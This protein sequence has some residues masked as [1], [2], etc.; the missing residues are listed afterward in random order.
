MNCVNCGHV[1]PNKALICYWCGLDPETGETPYKALRVSAVGKPITVGALEAPIPAAIEVASPMAVPSFDLAEMDIGSFGVAIPELPIIEIPPPPDIVDDS[2]F[3]VVRRRVRHHPI[4]RVDPMRPPET[5]PALPGCRRLLVFVAGLS[6]LLTLG[7]FL[8]VAVAAASFGGVFCLL[9]LLA[10]GA[11]LWVG[12]LT[13]RTGKRIVAATGE[14]Y[15]RIEVM[16]RVLR[17]V[18]PGVVQELPVNLPSRIGV[19]DEPVAYSELRA[20]ASESEETPEELA[21]DLFSGAI[22][23]LVGRDD[24]IFAR[25]TYPVETR[26]NLARSATAEVHQPVL[27]RRRIYTGPGELEE[28]IV[29]VLRTDEP[30]T[31]EELLR[32]LLG[33]DKRQRAAQVISVT[34][35]LILMFCRDL[36][37]YCSPISDRMNRC[38]R[39]EVSRVVAAKAIT[40]MEM[41]VVPISAGIPRLDRK[42]PAPVTKAAVPP[43]LVNSPPAINFPS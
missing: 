36:I 16:G 38:S 21:V 1:N 32:E 7:L 29:K 35:V 4:V 26:G 23:S 27:T 19:L 39:I 18:V 42:F 15:E 43:A 41:K 33:P 5:H 3:T 20:L 11:V 37:L 12:L 31:V 14:A 22:A 6:I 17:E 2:A 25:R 8:V 30:T 10:L 40:M 13:A 9:G 28:Q 24:V 34:T